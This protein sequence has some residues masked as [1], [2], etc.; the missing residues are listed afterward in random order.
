[1]TTPRSLNIAGYFGLLASLGIVLGCYIHASRVNQTTVMS[2]VAFVREMPYGEHAVGYTESVYFGIKEW[3]YLKWYMWI[4]GDDIQI[5]PRVKIEH[6]S[7]FD[8]SGNDP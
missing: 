3:L 7:L 5:D 1:M 8:S 2:G 4:H 6:D